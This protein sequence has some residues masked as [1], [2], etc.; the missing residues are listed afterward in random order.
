MRVDII[1]CVINS[2]YSLKATLRF[3]FVAGSFTGDRRYT[4]PRAP[5]TAMLLQSFS[6]LVGS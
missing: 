3:C 1:C 5:A 2:G 4:L 6:N